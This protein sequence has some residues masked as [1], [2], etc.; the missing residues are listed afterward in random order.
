MPAALLLLLFCLLAGKT[1][2]QSI[3]VLGASGTSGEAFIA[4]LAKALEP[5]HDVRRSRGGDTSLVVALNESE[6]PA[7]RQSGL[8]VLLVLPEQGGLA[9]G[10]NEAILYWAP[11]W[12]DQLLL[13][14]RIFPALRRV[15]L[16]LDESSDI[17]RARALREQAERLHIDV[18]YKVVDQALLIRQVAELAASNDILIAPSGSR[19]FTRDTLKPMLLAAYRQNRVFIGPSPA[20]VRAGALASLHVTPEALAAEVAERIQN[21]LRKGSW[22]ASSRISRFDVVTNPH[23]AR[24]LGLRLPE[25]DVLTR[26]LQAEDSVPWP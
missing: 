14:R 26:L 2:A 1:Y 13:A 21:R 25:A 20:V 22:G 7:A 10:D 17:P 16:L 8:P 9:I 3:Q 4:A 23:V 5:A 24:A 12:T 19:L 6:L 15:G 11:S 18:E